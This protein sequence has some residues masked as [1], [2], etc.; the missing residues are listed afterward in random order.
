MRD[1]GEPVQEW[2][3]A[4][5]SSTTRSTGDWNDPMPLLGRLVYE[6]TNRL[7]SLLHCPK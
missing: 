6:A 2:L 1:E 4:V 5:A 3:T 7:R